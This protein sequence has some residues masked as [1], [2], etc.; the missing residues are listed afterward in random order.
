MTITHELRIDNDHEVE[1]FLVDMVTDRVPVKPNTSLQK[2]WKE[3]DF[4]GTFLIL[5]G[6]V[7]QVRG[8]PVTI[9]FSILENG[10]LRLATLDHLG[11]H[12]L[13]ARRVIGR[14]Q[15]LN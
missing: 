5:T 11:K 8:G 12:V 3:H 2:F 1:K 15:L 10:V 14:D 13:A 9:H 4:Q 7:I 6:A